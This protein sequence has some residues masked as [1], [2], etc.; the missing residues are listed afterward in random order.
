MKLGIMQ[1]YF[2]PY[3]GYFELIARSDRWVVFDTAQYI[4]HGWVNR[5]RILHPNGGW[6]YIVV[7]L[8]K[9]S[10]EAAIREVETAP[11]AE[12]RPRILGQLM[13]YKKHAPH[14]RST[15][16]LVEH[17]LATEDTNLSRLNTRLL[18]AVC[19]HLGLAW[20][21]AVFSGMN[22]P[23]GPVAGPGDWALRISEALQ[24]REYINPPG[25]EALFDRAAFAAA[26]IRLTIQPPF[27]FAYRCGPYAFEP[28]LSVVDALMWNSPEEIRA[29]LAGRAALFASTASP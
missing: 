24:A 27:E 29:H 11:P 8:R 4:R 10:R 6:Q 9:H 7:P 17:A 25:G 16:E 2:F 21:H 3:L 18:G 28:G 14:F 1:P 15:M 19:S 26:G 5:N 13:H 12:W 23:L 22:L 20:Q